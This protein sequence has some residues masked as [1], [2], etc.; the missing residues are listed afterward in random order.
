MFRI[1]GKSITVTADERRAVFTVELSSGA[2][3]TMQGRSCVELTDGS[4]YYLDEAEATL[5][6]RKTGTWQGYGV[7][8]AL[9]DGLVL[10]TLVYIENVRD[11][12]W[13]V[14]RL[15]GDTLGQVKQ[16]YFPSAVDFNGT[17]K[18]RGYTVL[19][20]MQG[21]LVPA[22]E[23]IKI[24]E[25]ILYSREAYMPIFGQVRDGSGYLAIFDTP[26]DARFDLDGEN[27][28]PLFL[29]SLGRMSYPRKM[30]Y[31]FMED[32][33]YNDLAH[34]Y[35]EYLEERGEIV[36]LREK[37][38]HNPEIKRI[39]GTPVIHPDGI[40]T[41]IHPESI[42]YKPDD[43]A[44]ND[45]YRSFDDIGERLTAL[46]K[47]GLK[48][49]YLH[50]DGWGKDGYDHLHPDPFPPHERAGGAEA[51]KRLSETVRGLGYI[52]GIHDQDRDYYYDAPSFDF[53]N[54]VEN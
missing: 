7:D 49:G 44:N 22:G 41:I 20:R 21:T 4:V 45:R 28:R 5:T 53:N 35:R 12:L 11:D 33:D 3:W 50:L 26:F 19:P 54:A 46:K 40:C 47:K 10:H 48:R 36:T 42:Y 25:D 32:C 30:L 16:V 31:R 29:T 13:F 14:N 27:V 15:E 34:S 23:P 9:Q 17:E 37:C 1:Q 18:G 38:E 2:V 51:M 8:Y 6:E 39:I 43:P 52:F 24:K